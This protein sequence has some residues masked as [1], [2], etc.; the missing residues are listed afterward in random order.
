MT[1]D[2]F[3]EFVGALV[4]AAGPCVEPHPVKA[5]R[6]INGMKDCR[7]KDAA[8]PKEAKHV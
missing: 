1:T 5:P 6:V 4:E 3:P 7:Q 2:E 8:L